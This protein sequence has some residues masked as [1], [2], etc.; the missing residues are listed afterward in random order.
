M[1]RLSRKTAAWFQSAVT[2]LLRKKICVNGSCESLRMAIG[3][4]KDL[5]QLIGQ[6]VSRKSKRIGL[7]NL[8]VLRLILKSLR[9]RKNISSLIL[10][11]CLVIHGN[12]QLMFVWKSAEVIVILLLHIQKRISVKNQFIHAMEILM[13]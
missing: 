12:R 7:G 13:K 10:M 5:R 4:S 1:T 6:T 2:F 8:K 11:G 3:C 9:A